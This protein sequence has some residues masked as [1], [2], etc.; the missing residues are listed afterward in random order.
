MVAKGGARLLEPTPIE[1]LKRRL[2]PLA[3]AADAEPAGGRSA[4]RRASRSRR[5]RHAPRAPRRSPALGAKAVLVKGGHLA[6]RDRRATCCLPRRASSIVLE[7]RG[8]TTRHTHG[9]GCTLAS[10]IAAGSRRVACAMPWRGREPTCAAPSNRARLRP[11][12]RPAQSRRDGTYAL[13]RSRRSSTVGIRHR[14]RWRR[15]GA[16]AFLTGAEHIARNGEQVFLVGQ[17]LGYNAR[18]LAGEGMLDIGEVGAKA[19]QTPAVGALQAGAQEFATGSQAF[20]VAPCP[21]QQM[22]QP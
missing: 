1:A 6:G 13:K 9:T 12:A 15:P 5:R 8:S 11:G 4:D 16:K 18:G 7:A 21:R 10:A 20:G 2:L 3:A 17:A 22:L 19:D 14:T